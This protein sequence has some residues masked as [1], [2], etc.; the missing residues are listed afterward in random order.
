M[1]DA[2]REDPGL[3][4]K[5]TGQRVL[6]PSAEGDRLEQTISGTV[7]GQGRLAGFRGT[8]TA[9]YISVYRPDGTSFGSGYGLLA[10]DKGQ[11][12]R[13]RGEGGGRPVGGKMVYR[14]VH[15]FGSTAPE[16]SWLD[17]AVGVSEYEEDPATGDFTFVIYQW[18]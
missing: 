7:E 18:A 14:A 17:G 16:L 9:T 8:G 12:V 11:I 10:G 15:V 2:D 1:T 3:D 4:G 5:I 13:V 6:E